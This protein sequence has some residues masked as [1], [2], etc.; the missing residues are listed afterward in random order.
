MTVMMCLTYS[1]LVTG[2]LP[3]HKA[4]QSASA[5]KGQLKPSDGEIQLLI[6]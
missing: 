1:E 2:R 4:S 3:P 6:Q 5:A